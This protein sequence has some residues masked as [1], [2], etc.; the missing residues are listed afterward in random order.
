MLVI[1]IDRQ[2]NRLGYTINLIF[3][4]MLG[5][6]Y[7]VTTSRD[8]FIALSGAKLS[9]CKDKIFDELHIDSSDLMFQTNLYPVEVDYNDG[10]GMPKIFCN[11][12]SDDALGF[13][14]FA[15]TFYMVSRYEEYL[16]FIRDE[17]SRF[18]ANDSI[19][20]QKKFYLK[21]VVNIWAA[22]LKNKLRDKYPSLTFEE[23]RFSFINTIDIDSA[24]SYKYKGIYRT[25]GG[26]VRDLK[27][28]RI[29]ECLQRV[30]VL[31]NME[32]DPYD[33]FD[34]L[35]SVIG[36]YK[37]KSIFFFL[38]SIRTKYDKN[39]SPYN[40][41]FQML[42]KS[43]SD[44][45]QVGIHPS[46]YSLE[47][48]QYIAEH[49]KLISSII[50]KPITSSR[51]HYLRFRL[52][53]SFTDVEDCGIEDEYSMGYAAHIG[54]RAGICTPYNFYDLERDQ[55]TKLRVHPFA[56]MDVA[57]KNGLNMTT[58]QAWQIIKQLID[59]VKQVEGDFISVW[60]NESLSDSGQWEGWREV[61][62]QQ[63]EYISTIIKGAER[64]SKDI[65]TS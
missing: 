43:I 42:V 4:E 52:P 18:C 57:L 11:Y 22:Y 50:H 14:I 24:Y 29:A 44:Y 10:D 20:F 31:L 5:V 2:T 17:H 54:F 8:R 36:K 23:R 61:Y 21:P 63:I 48:P 37:L 41:H 39:I 38:F 32:K 40:H 46:Y 60:H 64:N 47:Y 3:R 58:S 45:A 56:F 12:S 33:C 30:R 49:I 6:E 7:M 35:Y 19:A 16:P 55:E 9:Y 27:D 62:Q 65:K 53:K 28:R 59:E 51:F 26:L 34:Y 1:Y 15:A 13:D 25:I